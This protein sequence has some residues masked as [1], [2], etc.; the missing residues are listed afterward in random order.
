MTHVHEK[1]PSTSCN[2]AN[3]GTLVNSLE[4]TVGSCESLSM[5]PTAHQ[6]LS[7][8]RISRG[9]DVSFPCTDG[10]WKAIGPLMLVLAES[11]WPGYNRS[12]GGAGV[13]CE[14]AAIGLTMHKVGS[15][16]WARATV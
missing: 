10:D 12:G 2:V 7:P 16:S 9:F 3:L 1:A 8:I 4:I 13:V 14:G 11:G 6:R 15:S 5:C